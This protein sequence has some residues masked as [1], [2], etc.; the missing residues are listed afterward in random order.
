MENQQDSVQLKK[1]MRVFVAKICGVPNKLEHLLLPN[2]SQVLRYSK[3]F[4]PF[5]AE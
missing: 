5:L 3:V 4:R 2:F 1:K